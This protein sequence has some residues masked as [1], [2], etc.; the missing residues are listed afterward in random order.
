[1]NIQRCPSTRGEVLTSLERSPCGY[2]LGFICNGKV[3]WALL[4]LYPSVLWIGALLLG[5][6][7]RG[8]VGRLTVYFWIP[9]GLSS[10]GVC[11]SFYVL[12][13][14]LQEWG[15]PYHYCC[16]V[17]GRNFPCYGVRTTRMGGADYN[18]VFSSMSLRRVGVCQ[19]PPKGGGE[20]NPPITTTTT[21]KE[22]GEGGGPP[23]LGNTV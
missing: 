6:V 11:I 19:N 2:L 1:M 23:P 8:G 3:C 18:P 17:D 20:N 4:L 22:E 7:L 5:I 14:L 12:F 9:W 10:V 15:G 21:P 16:V 13:R